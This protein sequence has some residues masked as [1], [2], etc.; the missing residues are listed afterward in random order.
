MTHQDLNHLFAEARKAPAETSVEE[1]TAWVG[2]AAL[3]TSGVLGVAAK[4]KLLIA[5]KSMLMLGSILGA[6]GITVVSV[7]LISSSQGPDKT[8]VNSAIISTDKQEVEHIQIE[9]EPEKNLVADL[10][11]PAEE[12]SAIEEPA[13]VASVEALSQV[14]ETI[15]FEIKPSRIF[16]APA[17]CEP[18]RYVGVSCA[19]PSKNKKCDS[20]PVKGSGNVVS[21]T[22][23][24]EAF[25]KLKISGIF[26]VYLLQGDK[27]GVRVEADDNLLEF[28]KTE[29]NGDELSLF[30]DCSVSIKK[31][32]KM[33][34]YVTVKELKY[35]NSHGIGDVQSENALKGGK[36]SIENSAVGDLNL[37][38]EYESL[39]MN[40]N[41]VG[42][43]LLKGKANN[44]EI[45]C[46]GV[47]DISA[48]ELITRT[49]DLD[50]SGVGDTKVYANESISVDF[51]GVG[52]VTYKG[53]PKTK[54][55]EKNGIGSVSSN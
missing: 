31:S 37:Q 26:D 50:H 8:P 45:D 15:W 1:V 53:D 51:T 3:T 5:K 19:S 38:L 21:E 22:R 55:I 29:M 41:G 20:D 24:I 10:E 16:T 46:S 52:N 7:A 12:N 9:Q 48:F 11:K 42:D 30:S 32:T 54:N 35:I 17:Q 28:I 40:Y 34:V 27:E 39:E 43:I 2:A 33:A 18:A 14:F 6:A 49:M 4:L 23:E 47:G 44:V 36:L 25:S 13:E